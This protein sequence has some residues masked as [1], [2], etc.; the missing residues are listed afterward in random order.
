MS[1][2]SD[3]PTAE[4]IMTANV[5]VGNTYGQTALD[6]V[7]NRCEEPTASLLREHGGIRGPLDDT[8]DDSGESETVVSCSLLVNDLSLNHHSISNKSCV[9]QPFIK[10]FTIPTK[11]I[12]GSFEDVSLED[13]TGSETNIKDV[14]ICDE[15]NNDVHE[16][17]LSI[18]LSTKA[19]TREIERLF[20]PLNNVFD[21]V[22]E[23]RKELRISRN[24]KRGDEEEVF[25]KEAEEGEIS[26]YLIPTSQKS[27]FNLTSVGDSI[28]VEKDLLLERFFG[29]A[30]LINQSVTNLTTCS[31]DNDDDTNIA[32]DDKPITFFD[33]FDPC[34]GL[35]F[36][37]KSVSKPYCEATSFQTLCG[38]K[39]SSC[40]ACKV[41]IHPIFGVDFYPA[42]ML[43]VGS[44]EELEFV[45]SRIC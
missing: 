17:Q 10:R 22:R 44:L 42:T 28:E 7:V 35:P 2:M 38:Y 4:A 13:R 31:N 36:L 9:V 41:I 1:G 16:I 32:N 45:I 39:T 34:S 29:F 23:A 6:I 27:R 5:N 26:L 11:T 8:D 14:N 40:A 15:T 18:H 30:E 20:G 25:S 33:Y 37:Y 12:V 19:T 24:E 3:A 21:R 43:W